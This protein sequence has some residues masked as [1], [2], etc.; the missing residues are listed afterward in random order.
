MLKSFERNVD[1]HPCSY[2][3]RVS[4]ASPPRAAKL[5]FGHSSPL[6]ESNFASHTTAIT[7]TSAKMANL[8]L[9]KNNF[10][11]QSIFRTTINKIY[12]NEYS[13]GSLSPFLSI[14]LLKHG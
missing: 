9:R 8:W 2:A 4:I 7:S 11:S 13:H 10:A 12:T 3:H 1:V 5:R 6:R 14:N